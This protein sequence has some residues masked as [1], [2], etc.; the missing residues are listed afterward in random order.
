[1]LRSSI[2]CLVTVFSLIGGL[3]AT[4]RSCAADSKTAQTKPV[5]T[6]ETSLQRIQK[7]VAKI[8]T[9]AS[10]PEGEEAVVSRLSKQLAI[11]P[12]TLREQQQTW[13]I[14]YGDLAMVYGFSRA[15]RKKATPAEVVELRRSGMDWNAIGKEIGV[16]VDAVASRMKKNVNPKPPAPAP[17]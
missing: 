4:P 12:E 3:L 15:S 8:N 2:V 6:K 9:E 5:T 17:K 1:P 13:G 11:P 16:N 7:M 10:T 14:G